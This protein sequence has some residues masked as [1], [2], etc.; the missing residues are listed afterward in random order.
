M[1]YGLLDC[2]DSQLCSE[3]QGEDE[4]DIQATPRTHWIFNVPPENLEA[5]LPPSSYG[6]TGDRI[7]KIDDVDMFSQAVN[8]PELSAQDT[9]TYPIFCLSYVTASG[10]RRDVV[11][12]ELITVRKLFVDDHRIHPFKIVAFDFPFEQ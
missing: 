10:G 11:L 5:R 3:L 1:R 9:S 2:D 4:V 7:T 8:E 12:L 6:S